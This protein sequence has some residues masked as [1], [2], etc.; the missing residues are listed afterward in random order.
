[1]VRCFGH[2]VGDVLGAVVGI[3]VGELLVGAKVVQIIS[4]F[5]VPPSR[6]HDIVTGVSEPE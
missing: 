2:V 3:E 1:M 6:P 5:G 4:P